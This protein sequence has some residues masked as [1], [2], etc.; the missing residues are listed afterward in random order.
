MR[1]CASL[2]RRVVEMALILREGMIAHQDRYRQDPRYR[3]FYDRLDGSL[4]EAYR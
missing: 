1:G 3:P 4:P 2:G